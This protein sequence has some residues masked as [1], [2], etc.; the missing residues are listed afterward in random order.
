[1]VIFHGMHMRS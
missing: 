1:M